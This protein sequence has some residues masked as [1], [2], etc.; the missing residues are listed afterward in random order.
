LQRD[1]A[2]RQGLAR[3]LH[4]GGAELNAMNVQMEVLS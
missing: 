2:Q 1:V 4:N 3:C